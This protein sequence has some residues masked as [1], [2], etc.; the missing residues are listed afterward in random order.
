MFDKRDDWFQHERQSHNSEWACGQEGHSRYADQAEFL[1][2]MSVNHSATV[3]AAQVS[4]FLSM[5]ERPSSTPS[6][7]CSLCIRE[8]KNL[9][10]HL[11]HHLEQIALFALPREN[12]V[13]EMDSEA[14][15]RGSIQTSKKSDQDDSGSEDLRSQSEW[16]VPHEEASDNTEIGLNDEIVDQVNQLMVPEQEASVDSSWAEVYSK[17]KPGETG[18]DRNRLKVFVKISENPYEVQEPGGPVKRANFTTDDLDREFNSL[19]D[20][21]DTKLP[22]SFILKIRTLLRKHVNKTSLTPRYNDLAFEE[23]VAA[24]FNDLADP[25]VKKQVDRD[26]SVKVLISKFVTNATI[27]LSKDRQSG[28]DV[29]KLILA[30]HLA[31]FVHF[32][33][34]TLDENNGAKHRP[35]LTSFLKT[36]ESKILAHDRDLLAC[37]TLWFPI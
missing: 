15:A 14:N 18:D 37:E 22:K 19:P 25:S 16:P 5:F 28:D 8:A 3:D 30:Q 33:Y 9:K 13:P 34:V 11:A 27:V 20:T 17:T 31:R 12:E 2:H 36:L 29:W 35:L 4:V 6:G 23:I 21:K 1:A 32:I 24:F 26:K 7:I 10:T